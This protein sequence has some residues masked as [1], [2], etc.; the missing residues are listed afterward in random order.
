MII[1]REFLEETGYFDSPDG[2]L[3]LDRI[4][5]LLKAG[6]TDAVDK[7]LNR[8]LPDDPMRI[9]EELWHERQNTR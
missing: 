7:I 5:E 1:A 9:L 2:H 3:A 6:D 8:W 4:D